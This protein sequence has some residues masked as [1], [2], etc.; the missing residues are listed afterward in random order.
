MLGGIPSSVPV[1][2]QL[3]F[4]SIVALVNFKILW[5][6]NNYTFFSYFFTLGSIAAFLVFFW[7]I[8]LFQFSAAQD[9]YKEFH[10]VFDNPLTYLTLLFVVAGLGIADNGILIV[11]GAF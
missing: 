1:D 6:T 4:F 7:V 9:I 8:N 10:F 11:K 5:S 3:V 2:G